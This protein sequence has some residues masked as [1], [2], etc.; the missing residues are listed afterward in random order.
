MD[1]ARQ[2]PVMQTSGQNIAVVDSKKRK[3]QT[4]FA[5]CERCRR[6]KAKVYTSPE[7]T[8][9]RSCSDLMSNQV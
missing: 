5:A 3:R 1:F 4:T 6:L 2:K 7:T 9:Y 8:L